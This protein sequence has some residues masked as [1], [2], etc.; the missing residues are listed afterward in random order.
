MG[1]TEGQTYC[2]RWNN[3]KSNL[4]EILEVLINKESYVDCTIY[5]DDH[6]QFKAHRVVLAANSPYFQSILQDVPMEHCSILFPDVKRFEMQALL[7]YMYTGEVN[8]TQSQIPRIM[9]IARQ[10]E[11]KGL[12]E[13]DAQDHFSGNGGN[14]NGPGAHINNNKLQNYQQSSPII[15]QS[16]N[17]SSSAQSSSASPPYNYKSHYPNMLSQ[18]PVPSSSECPPPQWPMTAASSHHLSPL[19]VPTPFQSAAAAAALSSVYES[20]S[21]M[22]PLKRKKLQSISS[23]LMSRD[24][25]I[26]RNVLAQPNAVDSSQNA[27]IVCTTNERDR[28][29]RSDRS[30]RSDRQ[31]TYSN[32]TDYSDKVSFPHSFLRTR[33]AEQ[34]DCRRNSCEFQNFRKL[35]K[36]NRNLFCLQ[37]NKYEE[38]HSPYTEKFEDEDSSHKFSGNNSCATQYG[39]PQ[40]KNPEW[41]RYKQYTRNDILQAIE[42]VRSGMSALQAARQFKVPSRTLYDKVKKLGIT[43]GRPMNRTIRRSPTSNNGSPAGFP[44]G[45]SGTRSPYSHNL[46]TQSHAQSINDSENGSDVERE[47]ECERDRK[48]HMSSGMPHPAAALLDPTFLAQAFEA[49]GGDIAAGRERLHA[50]ALAAAAH[51]AVN[52]MS[53]SPGTHGTARSPSPSVLMKFIRPPSPSKNNN[54][55][56]ECELYRSETICHS[57]QK[58][59]EHEHARQLSQSPPPLNNQSAMQVDPSSPPPPPPENDAGP[60]DDDD[61]VEDLS[62]AK[63]ENDRS[64]ASTSSPTLSPSMHPQQ[65]GVIVPP[66]T[67]ISSAINKDEILAMSIKHELTIDEK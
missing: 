21:D 38:P 27:P 25:P 42:C 28:C 55:A 52:G 9:E 60:D 65:L 19:Q 32:G 51:S 26:L 47:R 13:M 33:Q 3:H 11:V 16:T 23:M 48:N 35:N 43:A 45:I 10:L 14:G 31:S 30:D 64:R 53:T 66:I 18:S 41:K 54:A 20:G 4:V 12:F 61:L 6:V 57:S 7:E 2:L 63:N 50:I 36:I 37:K 56:S 1:G 67:K 34:F 8:V 22:N 15:S 49:R 44:F 59:A 29:D 62:M 40:P 46:E 24:T 5:V 58:S 17:I 39:Q